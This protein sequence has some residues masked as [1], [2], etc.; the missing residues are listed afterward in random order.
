MTIDTIKNVLMRILSINKNLNEESLHNLLVASAWD[1]SDIREG[2][3]IFRRYKLSGGDAEALENYEP[4]QKGVH[5]KVNHVVSSVEIKAPQEK[6]EKVT[7]NAVEEKK[8]KVAPVSV[9]SLLDK[10]IPAQEVKK[11]D[12]VM[13]DIK[14]EDVAF[15]NYI[16]NESHIDASEL[17]HHTEIKEIINEDKPIFLVVLDVILFLITLGLLIYIL[18]S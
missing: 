13:E 1:E 17:K 12:S 7:V 4:E 11:E 14:P 6:E 15:T 9:I 3:N 10:D 2:V 18:F 8:D 5:S 16:S